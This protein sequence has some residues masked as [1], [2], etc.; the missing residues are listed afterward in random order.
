[1]IISQ[2]DAKVFKD[3]ETVHKAYKK[4]AIALHLRFSSSVA[5]KLSQRA[6]DDNSVAVTKSNT[7]PSLATKLSHRASDDD[8]EEDSDD[9]SLGQSV[10]HKKFD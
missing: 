6:S 4:N 3:L 10:M 7:K 1:M 5:T 8:S 2:A 9:D